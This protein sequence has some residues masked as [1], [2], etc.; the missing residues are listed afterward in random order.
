VERR[1]F[2]K[3]AL[4]LSAGLALPSGV[5]TA[6]QARADEPVE[7]AL[8]SAASRRPYGGPNVIIVRFGGGVRR[9]ETIG[10]ETTYSPYFLREMVPRG[11]LFP[12]M[13]ISSEPGIET[14]HGQG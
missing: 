7:S 12:Q 1:D 5:P 8:S 4:S 10:P 9:R 14:S 3:T 6:G 2:L 11:V 13:E